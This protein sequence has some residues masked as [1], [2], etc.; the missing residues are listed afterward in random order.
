MRQALRPARGM[1]R[2]PHYHIA[3]AMEHYEGL[4]PS[5]PAYSAQE[6][7][8]RFRQF[9]ERLR[10]SGDPAQR[11]R[12]TVRQGY[13]IGPAGSIVAALVHCTNPLCEAPATAGPADA[14]AADAA[15]KGGAR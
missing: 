6:A 7:A 1:P 12:W 8:E 2:I 9:V 10:R 5:W 15:A 11:N 4:V 3:I 13:A 14:A